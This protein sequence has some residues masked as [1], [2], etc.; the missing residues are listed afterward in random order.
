MR[1]EDVLIIAPKDKITQKK[2]GRQGIGLSLNYGADNLR[3][4]DLGVN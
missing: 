4:G 3:K 1:S 2:V